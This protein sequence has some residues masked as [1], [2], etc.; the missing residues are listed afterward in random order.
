[1]VTE[2]LDFING[3]TEYFNDFINYYNGISINTDPNVYI[4]WGIYTYIFPPS[5][6]WANGGRN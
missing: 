2:K 3:I 5:L 6:G 4:N 1:M